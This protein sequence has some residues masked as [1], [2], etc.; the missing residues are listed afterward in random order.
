MDY[1]A[2]M[3]KGR[4]VVKETKD[5]KEARTRLMRA[6]SRDEGL[7][8]ALLVEGVDTVISRVFT[9]ERRSLVRALANP[10]RG[11][12]ADDIGLEALN[13][14]SLKGLLAWRLPLL[15]K[16]LGDALP[17]EVEESMRW[18][19]TMGETY[20]RNATFL[21][22]VLKIATDKRKA[23]KSQL[24]PEQVRACRDRAKKEAA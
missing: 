22:H 23:I 1:D 20:D 24:T 3:A 9:D 16:Q 10:D 14:A 18:C 11:T 19:R 8:H 5:P 15:Q 13:E 21:A 4:E 7:A 6:A 12:M 2:M 17:S